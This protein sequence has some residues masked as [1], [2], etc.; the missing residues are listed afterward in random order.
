M[1]GIRR[2]L[3]V[4]LIGLL[5]F[6]LAAPAIAATSQYRIAFRLG[7]FFEHDE[8]GDGDS[9]DMGDYE[10]GAFVLKKA[11]ERV[12][13]LN[14]RCDVTEVHPRRDLC[15]TTIRIKGKGQVIAAGS[16][17]GNAEH[18]LG[19]ITGGTGAFRSASGVIR[20]DFDNS[21]SLTIETD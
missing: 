2:A 3:G 12:G 15:W 8:N 16:Q 17:A 13:H 19:A 18:F 20:L 7:E 11:G 21:P 6:V 1:R 9:D 14:Y 4:G 5:V 10:V